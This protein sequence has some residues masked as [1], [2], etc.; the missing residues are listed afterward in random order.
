MS[1]ETVPQSILFGLIEP[2]RYK[3][4]SVITY[5]HRLWEPCTIESM[6]SI[7]LKKLGFWRKYSF[8]DSSRILFSKFGGGRWM[9][10]G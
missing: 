9:F 6:K 7:I 5:I 10:F 1:I 4:V 2:G 8:N 3:F